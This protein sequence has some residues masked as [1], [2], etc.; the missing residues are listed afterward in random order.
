VLEHGFE[1]ES[2]SSIWSETDRSD[3]SEDGN[4]FDE[5]CNCANAFF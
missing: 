3:S 1:S 5:Y 2:N 4:D